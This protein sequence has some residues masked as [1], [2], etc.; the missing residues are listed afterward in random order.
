MSLKLRVLVDTILV[1]LTF[2]ANATTYLIDFCINNSCFKDDSKY[3]GETTSG[4]TMTH[5]DHT[6]P[7]ARFDKGTQITNDMVNFHP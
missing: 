7:K 5:E 1:K 6:N 4:W 3:L 2:V